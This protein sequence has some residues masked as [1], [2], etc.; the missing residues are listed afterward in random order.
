MLSINVYLGHSLPLH[1]GHPRAMK[2]FLQPYNSDQAPHLPVALY[3]SGDS[4]LAFASPFLTTF[5]TSI[6]HNFYGFPMPLWWYF[7]PPIDL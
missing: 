3:R 7:H 5:R 6:N 4:Q 1:L 2:N